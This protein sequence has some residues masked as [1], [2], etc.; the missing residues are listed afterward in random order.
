MGTH[1]L[2]QQ[3]TLLDIIILF[4]FRCT[5]A[6]QYIPKWQEETRNRGTTVKEYPFASPT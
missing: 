4:I 5:T 1:G 6:L 3:N 2:R